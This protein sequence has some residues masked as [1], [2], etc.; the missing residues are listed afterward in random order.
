MSNLSKYIEWNEALVD[1]FVRNGSTVWYVTDFVLEHVGCCYG[2]NINNDSTY[3]DDFVETCFSAQNYRDGWFRV[4]SRCVSKL[5][6]E[7]ESCNAFNLG[8]FDQQEISIQDV[9]D[10]HVNGRIEEIRGRVGGICKEDFEQIVEACVVEYKETLLFRPLYS[11]LNDGSVTYV[12]IRGVN[13]LMDFALLLA[14]RKLYYNDNNV[15]KEFRYPY[16]SYLILVLLGFNRS[17]DQTWDGVAALFGSKGTDL[18][19]GER[20]K[21]AQLFEK[22][23]RDGLLNN[24]CTR[25]PDRYVKYLKYHSVLTP[26]IRNDFERVLYDHNISF[27]EG[28]HFND[29]RNWI[30]RATPLTVRRG[31]EG[32]LLD[33]NNRHYFETVIRSFDREKYCERLNVQNANNAQSKRLKGAFRFVVDTGGTG[34]ESTSVWVEQI[35]VTEELQN[36]VLQITTQYILPGNF[37]TKVS[38]LDWDDYVCNGLTYN[39]NNY[40]VGSAKGKACYYF[41]VINRQWLAEV[42]EPD[43]LA[44]KPCYFAVRGGIGQPQQR[45][46]NV[47]EDTRSK[48]RFFLPD[49]WRLFYTDSYVLEDVDAADQ[50][51]LESQTAFARV[52]VNDAIR[53]D[54]NGKKCYL[55]EEFPYI[56]FEGI[57]YPNVTIGCYDAIDKHPI[58]FEQKQRGDRIYLYNIGVV[59]SGEIILKICDSNGNRIDDNTDAKSHFPICKAADVART[60]NKDYVKFDKWFCP[61]DAEPYYSNNCVYPSQAGAPTWEPTT[62]TPICNEGRYENLMAVIYAL[63]ETRQYSN[64]RAIKDADLENAIRYEADIRGVSLN[65]SQIKRLKYVLC[66]LGILTHYYKEGHYYQTNSACLIPTGIRYVPDAAKNGAGGV[67]FYILGGAYSKKEYE[68]AISGATYVEY[69]KQQDPLFQLLPPV[70]KVG[71]VGNQNLPF[72]GNPYCTYDKLLGFAGRISD[73]DQTPVYR[74]Y[75]E[76][77]YDP[78]ASGTPCMI[79]SNDYRGKRELLRIDQYCILH[80]PEVSLSLLHNYVNYSHNK[81]IW[82]QRGNGDIYLKDE[83]DIPFYAKRALVSCYGCVAQS[84]Y[85]FG[86]DNILDGIVD[87]NDKLFDRMITYPLPTGQTGDD[88]RQTLSRMLGGDNAQIL[89]VKVPNDNMLTDLSMCAY[90]KVENGTDA[91]WVELCY[92]GNVVCYTD[93]DTRMGKVYCLKCGVFKEMTGDDSMNQKLSKAIKVYDDRYYL[94]PED[95]YDVYGINLVSHANGQS[96]PSSNIQDKEKYEIIIVKSL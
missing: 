89:R 51:E 65:P 6:G 39:D 42:C 72:E 74:K 40:V 10:A 78:N 88:F 13:S 64:R 12:N 56:V 46:L 21:I 86:V 57:D 67:Y 38:N 82:V 75:I 3:S 22:A 28:L 15:R 60:G 34:T 90:K 85:V 79:P 92:R 94:V 36:N 50:S 44:G 53:I 32:E 47:R 84:V 31:F 54:I 83:F 62:K 66:D 2:I 30:W 8:I 29:V 87:K 52:V 7:N 17:Q 73:F 76:G 77:S 71:Y 68:M 96:C 45:H 95:Y 41:E 23:I 33:N 69:V 9:Y 16:F 93:P 61:T 80:N 27:V 49:E 91:W 55:A 37:V 70:I 58:S 14:D 1:Y 19:A 59:Q 24:N 48:M 43:R 25:T 11:L 63:G 26:G 35:K 81:P 4:R 20:P 5:E 18:P